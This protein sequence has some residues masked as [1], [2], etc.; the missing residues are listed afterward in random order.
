MA[1]AVGAHV[2]CA[3]L[4]A[5]DCGPHSILGGSWDL[6]TRVIIKALRVLVTL[7]TKSHDPPSV[8]CTAYSSA[9]LPQ[10]C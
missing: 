2:D 6:V 8:A 4:A 10:R 7:L 1:E 9:A 3:C 5:G